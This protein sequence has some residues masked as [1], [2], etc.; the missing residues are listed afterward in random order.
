MRISS[1]YSSNFMFRTETVDFGSAVYAYLSMSI[2][3][4][5]H[6]SEEL[7]QGSRF[8]DD[9]VGRCTLRRVDRSEL[10]PFAQTL[11]DPR[12]AAEGL[13]T[14]DGRPGSAPESMLPSASPLTTRMFIASKRASFALTRPKQS[15]AM[16]NLT[17]YASAGTRK[18]SRMNRAQPFKVRSEQQL[19]SSLAAESSPFIGALGCESVGVMSP[20]NR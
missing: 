11:F 2:D 17:S 10:H 20:N 6:A 3:E 12:C 4:I 15:S 5:K 18:R 8:L 13:S 19:P 7:I 9:R 14:V 1:F 16:T